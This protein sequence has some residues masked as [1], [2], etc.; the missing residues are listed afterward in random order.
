MKEIAISEINQTKGRF[1]EITNIVLGV[2][3]RE[4]SYKG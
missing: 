3:D 1:G 4:V 2:L